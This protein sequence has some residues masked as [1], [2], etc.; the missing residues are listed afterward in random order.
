MNNIL[1]KLKL[2][3]DSMKEI[4][5]ER[6]N[7]G[8]II[9]NFSKIRIDVESNLKRLNRISFAELPQFHENF[10]NSLFH[11][12]D[13]KISIFQKIDKYLED[14]DIKIENLTPK[15]IEELKL[16][17]QKKNLT[18]MNMKYEQMD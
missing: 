12:Q 18:Y 13:K 10:Y 3:L 17:Y 8:I 2:L 16:D 7:L 15:K 5:K 6:D 11:F 4:K 1:N 14:S 9:N